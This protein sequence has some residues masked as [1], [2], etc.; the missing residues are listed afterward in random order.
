MPAPI[1]LCGLCRDFPVPSPELSDPYGSLP[2][3]DILRFY[4]FPSLSMIKNHHFGTL[5]Q[6][7]SLSDSAATLSPSALHHTLQSVIDFRLYQQQRSW[8]CS[9]MP[10]GTE[11]RTQPQD[12]CPLCYTGRFDMRAWGG[13]LQDHSCDF[14]SRPRYDHT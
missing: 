7:R 6:I 13:T 9:L 14:L 12:G 4:H 1:P 3:W 8:D 5:D 11:P 10:S 2:T